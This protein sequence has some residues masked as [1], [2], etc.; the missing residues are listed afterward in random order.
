MST[1]RIVIAAIVSG[2][3]LPGC[4]EFPGRSRS[5]APDFDYLGQQKVQSTM[6]EL[7]GT[8]NELDRIMRRHDGI[9]R[10]EHRRVVALL[11]KIESLIDALTPEERAGHP[12]LES[13]LGKLERD[14]RRALETVE[15]TP[16]N[17][18]FA[19]AISGACVYCHSPPI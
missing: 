16:P 5:P 19:G 8:V 7:A 11:R 2:M 14:V 6:S 10:D 3:F 13:E 18:Y 1:M 17:Y 4:E 12:L 15:W 9:D